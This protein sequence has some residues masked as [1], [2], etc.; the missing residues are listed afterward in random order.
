MTTSQR[1]G[2]LLHQNCHEERSHQ[3]AHL[4]GRGVGRE[5]GGAQV[6][7]EQG[8]ERCAQGGVRGAPVGLQ[9]FR[10]VLTRVLQLVLVQ[11]DVKHLLWK[12]STGFVECFYYGWV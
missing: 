1:N 12:R 11:N 10:Q 4:H 7:A 5:G 6:A 9:V 2:F 8:V 3:V